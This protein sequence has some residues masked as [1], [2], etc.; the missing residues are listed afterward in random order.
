MERRKLAPRSREAR[1]AVVDAPAAAPRRRNRRPIMERR[2][3]APRSREARVA[4]VDAPEGSGQK[5]KALVRQWGGK[6]SRAPCLR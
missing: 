4:V 5:R 6:L 3:L 2:K 1:V